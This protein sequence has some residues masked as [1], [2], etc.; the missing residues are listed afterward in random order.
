MYIG[1]AGRL[2]VSIFALINIID[3]TGETYNK[4]E[5]LRWLSESVWFSTNLLPSQHL[6][7]IAIDNKTAKL[8]FNYNNFRLYFIVL[9]NDIEEIV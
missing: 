4:G 3:A 9:F 2:V 1:N 6:H 5:L 8:S 7:W